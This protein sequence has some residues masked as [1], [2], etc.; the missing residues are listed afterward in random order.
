[1]IKMRTRE[2][3]EFAEVKTTIFKKMYFIEVELIYNVVL[4]SAVQ[5]SGSVA[6]ICTFF[7]IFFSTMGYH[8]LLNIVPCATQ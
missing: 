7:T 4:I 3:K 6:H 1:M 2:L 8:R 5:Q